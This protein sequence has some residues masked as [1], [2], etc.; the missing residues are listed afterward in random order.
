MSSDLLMPFKNL[1]SGGVRRQTMSRLTF[2]RNWLV[3]VANETLDI[4]RSGKY[5]TRNGEQINVGDSLLKAME[6]SVHYHSSHVFVPPSSS[7]SILSSTTTSKPNY[8][9]KFYI[10]Y[11]SSLNAAKRFDTNNNNDN[12]NDQQQQQRHVGI[13]NSASGK[14]PGGKFF[15]GTISQEDC[16]C[17]ATL[18]YPC[19]SQFEGKE[20]HFYVVNNKKKYRESSSACAIYSP[21]VPVIR[22]D[23][24]R[25]DLLNQYKEYSFVSLPAPNAFVVGSAKNRIGVEETD[26][27]VPKAQKPSSDCNN[28][29]VVEYMTI[30]DAMRDRLYRALCIFAEH[31]CTDLILGAF[32]CGVHGNNPEMVAS[33]FKEMLNDEFKGCFKN[34]IFAIQP[35]RV[36]NYDAFISVF[37][38]AMDL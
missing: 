27:I 37:P 38:Q 33:L 5:T 7:S 19:L 35:S 28:M 21:R 17:R 8:D 9:T 13:L 30:R 18:L 34:I 11:A 10:C 22:E 12:D 25:G 4:A 1:E 36:N 24:V 6:N 2:S 26:L 16:L 31:N 32:G 29:D 3:H 14:N 23:T 15:K 20:H